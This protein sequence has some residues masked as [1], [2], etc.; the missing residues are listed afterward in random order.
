MEKLFFSDNSTSAMI[1]ATIN[2]CA[3]HFVTTFLSQSVDMYLYFHFHS[4]FMR[5]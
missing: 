2:E 4:C 5:I 1:F 3:Y